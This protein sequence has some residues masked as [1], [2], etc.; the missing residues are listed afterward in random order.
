MSQC[1]RVANWVPTNDNAVGE[2]ILAEALPRPDEVITTAFVDLAVASTG[3]QFANAADMM[4]A[5]A[6]DEAVAP[7]TYRGEL[8]RLF[9]IPDGGAYANPIAIN[10]PTGNPAAD[11]NRLVKTNSV[12]VIAPGFMPMLLDGG[13]F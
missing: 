2:V 4:A 11:G 7:V 6:P 5:T 13:T 12:G 8:V 1:A 9:A 3:V 10:V